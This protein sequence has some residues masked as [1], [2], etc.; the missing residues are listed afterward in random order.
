MS[1]DFYEFRFNDYYCMKKC[2]YV[3]SDTY[4]RYCRDYSYDECP[5][6]KDEGGS[7]CYLSTACV[8]AMDLSD[9]CEELNILRKFRDDYMATDMKM[10]NDICEYYKYAP[11]IVKSINLLSDYKEIYKDIYTRLIC[12]CVKY[13]T[14]GEYQKAYKLYKSIYF[15]LKNKYL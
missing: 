4:Y 2:D 15:E 13:I 3:S 7:T 9:N 11:Q 1:C 10:K 6:Y 5:I 12:P 8:V 14:K